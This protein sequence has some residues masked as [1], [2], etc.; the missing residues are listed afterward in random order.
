MRDDDL[1]G[2]VDR[3]LAVVALHEPVAGRQDAAV[4]VG[5]VALRPVGRAAVLAAQGTALPAHARRC[6][7]PALVLRVGRIG[8]LCLQRG[9]GG[10]DRLQ[11]PLLVGHPVRRLVAAPVRAMLAILGRIGLAGL[12]QPAL[13]LGGQRRLGRLHPA[14]A[15]R[16]VARGI[17]LQL[18]PVH[19]HMPEL[20]QPRRP[21]QAQHLDEQVRQGGEV[22]LAEVGDGAEVRPVQAGDRHDVDPLLAGAGKLTRGVEAAAVAV[23]Q[24]RH[25]HAGMVG[26]VAALLGV[27]CREWPRGRAPRAPCRGRSA[28]GDRAARTHAAR[29]A[30]ASPDPRP[31]SETPW[32]WAK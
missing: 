5:E 8:S 22:A 9:L 26:R 18:G 11:P 10:P 19:G 30:K 4:R 1:M 28:P 20:H 24:Q 7:R 21:A 29:A 31:R 16:L 32:P 15:H 13:D 14:V 2:R 6:A 12:L 23:E 17:G 3:D 27:A 25:H